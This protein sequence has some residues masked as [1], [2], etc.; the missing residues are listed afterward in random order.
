MPLTVCEL[1]SPEP[2]RKHPRRWTDK[3][4]SQQQAVQNNRRRMSRDKGKTLQ[5]KRSELVEGSF[6][7]VCETGGAK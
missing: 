1:N 7:H 5:K 3:P 2:Q 4:E 6:A